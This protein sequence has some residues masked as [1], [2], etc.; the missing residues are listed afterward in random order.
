[1]V[2]YMTAA[3]Q[4]FKPCKSKIVMMSLYEWFMLSNTPRWKVKCEKK[5][6][7]G[8]SKLIENVERTGWM[9]KKKNKILN[10]VKMRVKFGFIELLNIN[11][12]FLK[13]WRTFF[14][15]LKFNHFFKLIILMYHDKIYERL[16]ISLLTHFL[17]S[18]N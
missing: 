4:R 14:F 17:S 18:I 10:W 9:R 3:N 6:W 2:T 13:S 15:Y 1:M 16:Q 7:I 8:S 11:E 5:T 12:N